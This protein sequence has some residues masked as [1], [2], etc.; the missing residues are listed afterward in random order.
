MNKG[1]ILI[2]DDE[3]AILNMVKLVLQKE[4]FS[5]VDSC[6]SGEEALTLIE[7]Y[8]YDL[9]ILD[10][11]LPGMSGYE[12]VPQIRATSNV[13]IFFLSAKTSDLDKLTGFAYGCD[14]Y[15]PKPFNPL[16]VVARVKA[17]LSRYL[18][19]KGHIEQE[20]V[21]DYGRFQLNLQSAELIVE[22]KSI[23]CT[24]QIYKLLA[25]FCQNC[26]RVFTKEQLYYQVWGD[27][28]LYDENTVM[29]HIR[30]IREKIEENPSKPQYLLTLRGLGYKMVS[31]GKV[32]R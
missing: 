4:G 8:T 19:T 1:K 29:V 30:K 14:D 23:P 7:Q 20:R 11:M 28:L 16:E 26:N 3:V 27:D 10:I 6:T 24:A 9:I 22:G 17:Q 32:Q 18:A 31:H 13:P 21:L 5:S 12:L 15:I 25:F 2:V